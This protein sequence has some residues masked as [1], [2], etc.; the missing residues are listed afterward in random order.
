MPL[1]ITGL[2]EVGLQDWPV[3]F[4]TLNPG[5]FIQGIKGG[6]LQ[7]PVNY[8]ASTSISSGNVG[9]IGQ[10][11]LRLGKKEESLGEQIVERLRSMEREK[12]RAR[13][14]REGVKGR[15]SVQAPRANGREREEKRAKSL[16]VSVAVER[17]AVRD[18]RRWEEESEESAEGSVAES[19]GSEGETAAV[20]AVAKREGVLKGKLV[21]V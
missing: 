14:G 1:S 7:R 18:A 19:S 8:P 21:D 3:W 12:E 15:G 2:S 6:R 20:P 13:D 17:A 11:E 9:R 10:A 5:F 16:N 4:R